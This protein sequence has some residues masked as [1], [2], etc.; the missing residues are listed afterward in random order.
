MLIQFDFT[1]SQQV[2]HID[3]LYS[4]MKPIKIVI[5]VIGLLVNVA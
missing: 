3:H 4:V 1:F 2:V 5:L